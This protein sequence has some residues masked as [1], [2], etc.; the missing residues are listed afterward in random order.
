MFLVLNVTEQAKLP[1]ET[2]TAREELIVNLMRV[3]CQW[4]ETTCFWEDKT[5][6]VEAASCREWEQRNADIA[7]HWQLE[8]RTCIRRLA[9]AI[10]QSEIIERVILLHFWRVCSPTAR[11]SV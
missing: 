2:S 1:R 10:E 11:T 6:D 7:S 8:L 5:H 9:T 3:L 4:H